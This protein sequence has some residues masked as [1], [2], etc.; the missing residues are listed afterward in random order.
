MRPV[1]ALLVSLVLLCP[2]AVSAADNPYVKLPATVAARP[3]RLTVLHAETNGKTVRWVSLSEGADVLP[4][5]ANSAIFSAPL[6]GRYQVLAYTALDDTPSDPATTTIVVAEGPPAPPGPTPPEPV[7]PVPP[8]PVPP[9]PPPPA[10]VDPFVAALQRA[11][12]AE[13]DT[14]KAARKTNLAALYRQGA[15]VALDPAVT[16]WGQLFDAMDRAAKSPAVDVAGKLAGMQGVIGAELQK[17]LSTDRAQPLNTGGRALA[18]KQF[19]RV[20][21]ALEQVK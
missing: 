11:Y 16:T 1:P 8:A 13:A 4:Y 17:Q 19:D 6:A 7:P 20:A 3:G 18:E 15:K 14:Q 12:T 2:P 21:Q 5:L 10:P 9:A